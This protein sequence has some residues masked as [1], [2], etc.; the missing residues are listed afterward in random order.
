VVR[1]DDHHEHR[2]D[3][4]HHHDPPPP[5]D[6]HADDRDAHE[7]RPGDVDRGHRG[8]LV[9]DAST[10]RSVHRLAVLHTG[11]DEAEPGK[12]ARRR[13]RDHLH[14]QACARRHRDRVAHEGV[15][16]AMTDVQPHEERDRDREV[17]PRVVEVA[18][19]HEQGI[20]QEGVL[21]RHLAREVQHPL[22]VPHPLGMAD[23][24]GHTRDRQ[25]GRA[26]PQGE[27]PEHDRGFTRD[28]TD[29]PQGLPPGPQRRHG[30]RGEPHRQ[31]RRG[32]PRDPE[33][34]HGRQSAPSM[35]R[36]HRPQEEER[37]WT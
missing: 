13:N 6:A 12:H 2:D 21:H 29:R 35:R 33:A 4:V 18:D 10:N 16:L 22:G 28:A 37:G 15:P 5:A 9:G 34:R 1:G 11:V 7:H 14:E 26:L 24:A 8:E 19:L 31:Q 32:S 27:Q 17:Q 23:R 20:R 3:R 25:L 30:H 36:W